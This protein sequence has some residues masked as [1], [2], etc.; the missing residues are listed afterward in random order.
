[1]EIRGYVCCVSNFAWGG[2]SVDSLIRV[3][4]DSSKILGGMFWWGLFL[5]R[6]KKI[7]Q[8]REKAGVSPVDQQGLKIDLIALFSNFHD[9]GRKK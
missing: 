2:S 6:V 7:V 8:L 5:E 1:M 9:C 4:V 3:E